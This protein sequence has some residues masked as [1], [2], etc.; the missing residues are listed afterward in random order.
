MAEGRSE[1]TEKRSLIRLELR[2]QACRVKREPIQLED[3]RLP[4]AVV[5]LL[6]QP[7]TIGRLRLARFCDEE[8]PVMK[9]VATD[10]ATS[11]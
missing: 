10:G 6:V 3:V 2:R 1:G 4:E 8:R 11:F 9:L 7:T 5:C